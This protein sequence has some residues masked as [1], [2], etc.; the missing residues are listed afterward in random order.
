MDRQ[1][2]CICGGG[3]LGHVVAGFIA[4]T[5][6]WKV[7]IL[8]R[9]PNQWS[10]EL[11]INDIK[12]NSFKGK[13]N[14]ISNDPKE[15]IEGSSIVLLCLPGFSIREELRLIKNYIT[16]ETYVGSIVSS[17]GF[18]F[19]AK[20]I[21]P[22]QKSFGFQRVPFIAR[23]SEYGKSA[24]LLGYKNDLNVD[25]ENCP[26]REAFCKTIESLFQTPTHLLNNFY[27]ASLT[28]SN[29]LLHTSRLYGMLKDWRKGLLYDRQPYFYRDWRDEDSEL[30]IRMDEE[31][32]DLL[33]AL[34]VDKS[35]IPTILSYYESSDAVSLTRKI[36]SITAF[37]SILS[38]MIKVNDKYAPDFNSR[39]FLEDFPYGLDLI[40]KLCHEKCKH[41][42]HIDTVYKWGISMIQ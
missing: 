14:I 29:P 6:T 17:T 25:I 5:S 1:Q 12:G 16:A 22:N 21:M 30:L 11:T 41:V 9:R 35:K 3:S 20:E 37:K 15:V 2:I 23:V 36:Q 34:P 24:N 13:L 18:F 32:M 27:E 19:F 10:P 7:N 42:P 33:T 28:N 40:H 39:Y 4:A 38:P 31:F 26:D 8:T